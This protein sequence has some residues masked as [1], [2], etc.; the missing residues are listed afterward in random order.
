MYE[1]HFISKVLVFLTTTASH[2]ILVVYKVSKLKPSDNMWP[3]FS[4]SNGNVVN[5]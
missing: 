5:F 3:T 1:K 2:V 4:A